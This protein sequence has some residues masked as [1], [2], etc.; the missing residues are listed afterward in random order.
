MKT[1]LSI[2]DYSG[3]WS[4][5]FFDNGWNVIRWDIK[6]DEFMDIN[7]IDSAETALDLFENVD[8]LLIAFPCTEFA[9]SGA[10]WWEEKARLKPWL[11]K[12]A[13][14]LVEQC[15]RI[16]DLFRPTDPDY[17]GTFFWAM[18]NPVGRVESVTTLGSPTMRFNPCDYAG[19]LNPSNSQLETLNTIRL[20]NGIGVTKSERDFIMEMNAYTKYTC[21][22][23]EFNT[24]LEKRFVQPVKGCATGSPLQSQGGGTKDKG[25]EYRSRTPAGF[26]KAFYEANKNYSIQTAEQLILDL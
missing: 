18:E 1:C 9:I 19:W 13:I 4:Q 20:K 26:A 10:R 7:L 5:P 17:E 2:F 6:I 24:N 15:Q 16:V 3:E 23:G 11:L 22:W 25:K 8:G 14:E 21:L 12:E